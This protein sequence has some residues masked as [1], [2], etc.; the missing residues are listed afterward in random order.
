LGAAHD[1]HHGEVSLT[2]DWARLL[3]ACG[4]DLQSAIDTLPA[5]SSLYL[6]AP[7]AAALAKALDDPSI[8]LTMALQETLRI[9][10]ARLVR[11]RAL[12]VADDPRLRVAQVITSL[13]IGGAERMVL[14]LAHTLPHAGRFGF[15]VPIITTGRPAREAFP[16]P[17]G[18][19]DV[20]RTE[21]GRA[22]R[23]TAAAEAAQRLHADA[24]HLHL[25]AAEDLDPFRTNGLP[26]VITLHN[27][28][29]GWPPGIENLPAASADLLVTC[30]QRVE[31]DALRANL[32]IPVRT[33]WN[34]IDGRALEWTPALAESARILRRAWSIGPHDLIL[35]AL[36][37]PRPQKRLHLLP[38]ILQALHDRLLARGEPRKV[39][40]IIA[41]EASVLLPDAQAADE[42]L[43]AE[44]A[45]L[46][47]ESRVRRIGPVR[48]IAPLLHA[49]DVLVSTSAWEGLSLAQMEAVAA[50][51]PVVATAV[52]GTPELAAVMP[53][54]HTVPLEASPAD[55]AEK[56]LHTLDHE[57]NP[58]PQL[59]PDFRRDRM[60]DRYAQ[61]LPRAIELARSRIERPPR[62]GL[63]LITNNFSTGG[64]QSSARRLLLALRDRGCAVRA[65]VVQEDPDHPTPGRQAL[66]A[67]G[68]RVLAL[69]PP[70][71]MAET[72]PALAVEALLEAIDADPPEAVVFWNL[73]TQYK[74]L[75]AGLL[76][77][78]RVFD[79]SPGEMNFSSLHN[80]F[81]APRP[82]LPYRTPQDYGRRLAGTIVKFAAE[83]DTAAALRAPV[84]IIPNGIP[85][86]EIP[87]ARPPHNGPLRLGTAVRLSPQKKLEELFDALRLARDRMP[88]FVLQIAGG[89]DG[90]NEAYAQRLRTA[91]ADLPVQ[92]LGE[93]RPI[94]PFLATLDLFVMIS[95][96]AGCPNAS[97]E[98]MAAGL[99]LIVTDVGGAAEQ[100]EDN[101]N[102]RLVPRGD[103]A[104]LA[105]ALL[106][107]AH[108]PA[109]RARWSEASFARAHGHFSLDRMA[110][111]YA[112]VLFPS[113]AFADAPAADSLVNSRL[114]SL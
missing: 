49:A 56:I 51:L 75:L 102:G 48:E 40:L 94:D 111:A 92:W 76:I 109:L 91:A 36:A 42:Q 104:A 3:H 50:S 37:N 6:D 12:D 32:P 82:G 5:L 26:T 35:L 71:P 81:A 105:A 100:V 39:F 11:W 84:H 101:L 41:G 103:P 46:G 24:V 60:A 86:P 25:L 38:A 54:V 45:R 85:V 14:D 96:P 70:P 16:T 87:P 52:G 8:A 33:A 88:P 89:P 98:A 28:R 99:P 27:L 79:V 7:L 10:N 114:A 108:D 29:Q 107:A 61:L 68:L 93:V 20:S 19:V 73:I 58:A 62:R 17:P 53:A 80:Y 55:F 31:A 47:L 43:T 4:G 22:A 1:I 95:E 78:H 90:D 64:A 21:G 67:A 9:H 110:A 113:S 74:V 77:G 13:Q 59:A 112:A 57:S 30:A 106:Q 69:D 15:T 63:W 18:T 83:R 65:A 97:L 2:A 23:M 66:E 44:I 34:G 72:D